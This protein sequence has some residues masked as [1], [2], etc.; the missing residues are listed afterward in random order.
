MPEAWIAVARSCHFCPSLELRSIPVAMP[1]DVG[2]DRHGIEHV[3]ITQI[4]RRVTETDEIGGAVVPDDA[5]RA[6]R[7]HNR[8]ALGVRAGDLAAALLGIASRGQG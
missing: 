8:I 5:A 6:Q 7:L 3:D 4:E 1:E 2:E